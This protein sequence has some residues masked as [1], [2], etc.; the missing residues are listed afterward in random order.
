MALYAMQF[1]PSN[2]A[3]HLAPRVQIPEQIMAEHRRR[4]CPGLPHPSHI[5]L[6]ILWHL[7][8]ANKVITVTCN[9][10]HAYEV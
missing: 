1:L 2:P 5:V 4:P 7:D 6:A 10:V 3:D 9:H 8:N